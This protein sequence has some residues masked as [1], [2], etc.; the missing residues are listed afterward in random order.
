MCGP[1]WSPMSPS[2]FGSSEFDVR[3]TTRWGQGTCLKTSCFTVYL[4]A[5]IELFERR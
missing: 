1:R 3:E 2:G 4:F 5:Q